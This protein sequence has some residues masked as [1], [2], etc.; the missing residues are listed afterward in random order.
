MAQQLLFGQ[1]FLIVKASLSDSYTRN[2]V[3]L[4]WTSDQPFQRSLPDDTQQAQETHIHAPAG[5][6]PA[7]P[8]SDQPQTDDLDRAV[9]GIG[10]RDE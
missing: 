2:S 4:L 1:G 10:T 3:G 8:A 9:T 7:I 5:F 6:E